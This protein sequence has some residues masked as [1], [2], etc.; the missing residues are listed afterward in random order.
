MA[1]FLQGPVGCL[2]WVS[3]HNHV[4]LQHYVRLRLIGCHPFLNRYP[5]LVLDRWSKRFG[6]I[7]SMWLGSQLFVVV[8]DPAIAKDLLVNNGLTFSSRKEMFIKSQTVFAGR[9]ITATPYNETWLR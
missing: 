5:E 6:P 4:L 7:Y 3:F 8:S 2:W 1:R 9:G